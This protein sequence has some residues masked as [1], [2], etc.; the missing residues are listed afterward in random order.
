MNQFVN[1][2]E[3][4]EVI[5]ERPGP[6]IQTVE[7]IVEVPRT[8]EKI[9]QVQVEVPT[10]KEVKVIEENIVYRDRIK[11]IEKIVNHPVI[12]IQ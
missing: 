4:I 10:I 7:K 9:V 12:K 1:V 8:I 5:V 6:I 3:I 11:E 2:P